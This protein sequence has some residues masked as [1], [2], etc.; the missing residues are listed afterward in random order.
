VNEKRD[1]GVEFA[2]GSVG[3]ERD[4]DEIAYAADI[5]QDLIRAFFGETSAELANHERSVLPPFVRLSTPAWVCVYAREKG[6]TP[7][8]R[9]PA[10]FTF[11]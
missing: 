10:R 1:F 4:L 2:E 8:G 11:Q 3:G 5:D 7:L 9:A 6:T